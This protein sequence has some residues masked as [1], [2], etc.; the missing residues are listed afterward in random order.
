MRLNSFHHNV[1]HLVKILQ[2]A[3][4]KGD[5]FNVIKLDYEVLILKKMISSKKFQEM[6]RLFFLL[7]CFMSCDMSSQS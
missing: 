5:K 4:L 7:S 1:T 2:A 6:M 3:Y